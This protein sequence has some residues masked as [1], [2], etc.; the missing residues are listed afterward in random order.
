M[1]VL[2]V[3]H[4]ERRT[5]L[6]VSDPLGMIAK[7][8]VEVRAASE[9]EMVAA[10]AAEAAALEV[11]S[12]VVGLPFNMDGTEGPRAAS[13]RAFVERLRDAVAPI[14]VVLRDERLTSADAA[15]RLRAQG[16]RREA[17]DKTA[18]NLVAASIVLQEHL[19]DPR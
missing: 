12:I 10:V 2:G 17:A 13:V 7:P 19:D 14:D 16:R 3:D 5:G 4:G 1:R 11:G 18:V 6:A 15:A 8:H 9:A